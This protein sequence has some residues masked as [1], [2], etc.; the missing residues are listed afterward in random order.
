M[1]S[2]LPIATRGAH[3]VRGP[4]NGYAKPVTRTSP[5]CLGMLASMGSSASSEPVK[6][7]RSTSASGSEGAAKGKKTRTETAK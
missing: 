5:R 7:H 1:P 2:T 4:P 3:T 6:Y